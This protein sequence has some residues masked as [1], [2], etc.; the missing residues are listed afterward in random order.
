VVVVDDDADDGGGEGDDDDVLGRLAEPPHAPT[1]N[2][3]APAASTTETCTESFRILA[4][5]VARAAM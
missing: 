5:L 2:P 3:T 1:R 4:G